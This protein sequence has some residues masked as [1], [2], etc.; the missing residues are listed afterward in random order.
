MKDKHGLTPK[1]KL[2]A[3]GYIKTGNGTK[4]ALAAYDTDDL[5][6]AHVIASRELRKDTL[7]AYLIQA[8]A[9]RNITAD[10]IYAKL[11]KLIDFQQPLI[12]P[13]GPATDADGKQIM[14]DNP[15]VQIEA[16]KQAVDIMPQFQ[17][18][19]AGGA[20]PSKHLHLH[21]S[22][23]ESVGHLIPGDDE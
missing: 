11:D 7:Q 2:L 1:Q 16:I 13:L 3:D 9:K 22:L 20:G 23:P 17:V 18:A 15:K 5:N 8:A 6:V 12:T 21:G 4:A 19:K 14:V 10:R